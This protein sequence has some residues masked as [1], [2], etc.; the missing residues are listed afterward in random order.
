MIS[1]MTIPDRLV[2]AMIDR[3]IPEVSMVIIIASERTPSSGIW[4]AMDWIFPS[5]KKLGPFSASIITSAPGQNQD[6]D[7]E[8]RVFSKHDHGLPGYS[9]SMMTF[10]LERPL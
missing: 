9:A 6:Q 5:L 2:E 1:A 8:L 3:L 7:D 10:L 4:K